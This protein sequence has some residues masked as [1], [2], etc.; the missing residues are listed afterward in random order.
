MTP[1]TRHVWTW[2]E[3]HPY[4]QMPAVACMKGEKLS[5]RREQ[6]DGTDVE[7]LSNMESAPKWGHHRETT[8]DSSSLLFARSES[9][10]RARHFG[11]RVR[12]VVG[13]TAR[14]GR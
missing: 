7:A 11:V 2:W 10:R 9:R 3:V 4:L 14:E 13:R 6:K 5:G 12:G 8:Q 1:E